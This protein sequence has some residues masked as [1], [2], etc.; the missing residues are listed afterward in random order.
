[1]TS[2]EESVEQHL[3]AIAAAWR[4][5]QRLGE[6]IAAVKRAGLSWRAIASRTGV[7][8]TTARRWAKPHLEERPR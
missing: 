8:V 3:A 2:Q 7:P 4:S 5:M 6:R 1:M